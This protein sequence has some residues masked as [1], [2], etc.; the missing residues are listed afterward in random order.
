MKASYSLSRP[1]LACIERIAS[2]QLVWDFIYH[3]LGTWIGSKR[4]ILGHFQNAYQLP[5]TGYHCPM[6]EPSHDL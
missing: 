6:K 3:L 4:I 2:L 1:W 5:G